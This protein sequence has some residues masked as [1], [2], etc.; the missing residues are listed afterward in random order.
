MKCKKVL[1]IGPFPKPISGVSL[2]NQVVKETLDKSSYFLT[3]FIN[4]SYPIF[5]EVIGSF[6]IKKLFFY[7]NFNFKLYKIL[8][9]DV[10]YITPGQT[11]FGIAKYTFFILLASFLKKDLII[12]VH[13]NFLGIQYKQLTGLKK[14]FF[15][16]LISKFTKGIVLS[17]SL[18]N[19]LTP[20]LSIS[21]IF[22][23]NNFAEDYLFETDVK[24]SRDKLRIVYLS[25]LMEDKGIL[26][27]LDALDILEK[28]EIIRYEAKIAG[29]ID[30][31]LK[32]VIINKIK[33]LEF[34]SYLGVV[35]GEEK[36]KL[37]GWSNVFV[38]PTYYKMEG[39]PI[40]ILEALA[41]KNV[42]VTTNHAGISD[43]IE[44]QKNGF[45]VPIKSSHSISNSL[46]YL[47]KNKSKISEIASYNKNYFL[48]KF[49][50]EKFEKEIIKI[51]N[52]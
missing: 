17:E 47:D 41:T 43:I 19:N 21:N 51:I 50:I 44:D 25:N 33:S 14:F 24:I 42:I 49:T 36:R 3:D 45:I 34:T 31:D 22:I 10:V 9:S 35:Y 6:S 2:A 1:I 52:K 13:G 29:N 39:Q 8:K 4:T 7:L 23:L 28:K 32:E 18:K 46:L 16:F 11:F 27:F 20:F 40:S 38:L 30:D 37:L 5:E 12:H 26:H 48:S 15:S